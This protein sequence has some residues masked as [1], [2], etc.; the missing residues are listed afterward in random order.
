VKICGEASW[1][2]RGGV[3]VL[4]FAT[5]IAVV[6]SAPAGSAGTS[7]RTASPIQHVVVIYLENHSF[8]NVL[9]DW[10]DQ[11]AQQAANRC[12]AGGMP[13]SVTLSSGAVVA[14][15][16]TPDL[17]PGVAHT[18][19]AQQSALNVKNGG[20]QMNGWQNVG[21]C[22][23]PGYACIS[24]YQPS[25]IPNLSTLASQYAI[26]DR[27][28]SLADSPSWGGHLYAAMGSLDGFTG[29]NPWVPAGGT[30]GPGWGCDS[31]LVSWWV[32]PSGAQKAVPSCV[33]DYALPTANGGAFRPSPVSYHASIFDELD[34]AGLS[35]KIYG[36]TQ[37]EPCCTQDKSGIMGGYGW[38]ICPSL[39]ECIDNPAQ[40]QNLVDA[41]QFITDAQ[42]GN[43]PAYSVVSGGGSGTLVED[44]CHN[45]Y[46]MT[47]C[48]NYIG[49]LVSAVESGPDWLSTA[50]FIAFDDCGCFYDQVP[51]PLA[52]DYTQEGP[53]VPLII[54][55][56]YAKPAYSDDTAASFAS[57][58]AYA[59]QTFGLPPMGPNDAQAYPF[60]NAFNYSQPPL[61]PVRIV[62]RPLPAQARHIHVT[63]AELN[64]PS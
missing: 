42:A 56:P 39:A 52:P 16:R 63:K 50:I 3:A 8:D 58:L 18:V 59:E 46:S 1:L 41:T 25:S 53:R 40:R 64:D 47:A 12:P 48:D 23:A 27:T 15:G 4:L 51:P 26:S 10:C 24:G 45:G 17:I 30:R 21:G 34:T 2:G 44:S 55:S 19:K 9:G 38:S 11:A 14:P 28:F 20:P 60:T 61:K 29:E 37:A 31:G 33:P 32:S 13:S 54:V 36:A 22:G 43:L 5:A 57:I 62:A 7:A 35:W 49:Q 6:A